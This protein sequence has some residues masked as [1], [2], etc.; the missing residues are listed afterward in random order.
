MLWLLIPSSLGNEQYD[1]FTLL[2]CLPLDI[3]CQILISLCDAVA[4]SMV[5]LFSVA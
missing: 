5:P 3:V 2:R 1:M 4:R